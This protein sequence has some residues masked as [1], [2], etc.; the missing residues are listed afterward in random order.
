MNLEALKAAATS[1]FAR[2][3]LITQKHSPK[4]LFAAGTIGVI[5]TVVLAC[6]ATLKVNDVLE[7]TEKHVDFISEEAGTEQISHDDANKRIAKVKLKTALEIAK[8]YVPAMGLGVVSIAALT[9]SHVILTKRNTAVMA[10]YAGLDRAYKE[11]RQRVS[12]E[13]GKD[14]DKKFAVGGFDA[15]VEEKTADGKN[16]LTMKTRTDEHSKSGSPYAVLFDETSRFFTKQP[17]GNQL[18]I[19]SRQSWANDKLR[20]NGHLFLNEVYDFLGVPRTKAGACVGWVYRRDNEPKNGDNYVSFGVFEGDPDL[21]EAFL[22][23]EYKHGIWLDF[24]VDGM[25]LDL[26]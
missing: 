26:I 1:K 9:G 5:G 14:I 12:D 8:L 20:A 16:K 11:Y 19:E 22:D 15:V 25:I 17:G 18:F 4:I 7:T 21:V 10:A 13:Y 6:R 2:Q 3:V 24:N 23:G